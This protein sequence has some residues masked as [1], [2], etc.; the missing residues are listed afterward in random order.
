MSAQDFGM[1]TLVLI[2]A[3]THVVCL[4]NVTTLRGECR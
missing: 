3:L 1:L 2:K 4:L